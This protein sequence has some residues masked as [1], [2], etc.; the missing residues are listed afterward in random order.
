MVQQTGTGRRYGH[1]THDVT[2]PPPVGGNPLFRDR[3]CDRQVSGIF[4]SFPDAVRADGTVP[5]LA[6]G[7]LPLS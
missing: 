5:P 4:G 7:R 3:I 2:V 1:V 6:G